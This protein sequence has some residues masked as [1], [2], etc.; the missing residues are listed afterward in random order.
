MFRVDL[1]RNGIAHSALQRF[2]N[3]IPGGIWREQGSRLT[4]RSHQCLSFWVPI[5]RGLLVLSVAIWSALAGAS[6]AAEITGFR[7]AD[8]S[9]VSVSGAIQAGDEERFVAALEAYTPQIVLLESPGGDLRSALAIGA[10]IAL[11]GVA[12][13]VPE[14]QGCFSACALIWVAGATRI[15][16][17]D[18]TIGVHGAYYLVDDIDGTSTPVISS[19]GNASIG[20]YLNE[21]GLNLQA[22]EFF[23]SAPPDGIARLT[24]LV[25]DILDI[26]VIVTSSDGV[27]RPRLPGL[28]SS[29]ELAARYAALESFC[30]DFFPVAVGR[31]REQARIW[32]QVVHDIAGAS[33]GIDHMLRHSRQARDDLERSGA[34]SW[35]LGALTSLADDSLDVGLDGPSF[36]CRRAA[37]PSEVA[38]CGAPRLWVR[39][40]ALSRI[41]GALLAQ[42]GGVAELREA[43]RAWLRVR[44]ACG[45]DIPCLDRRYRDRISAL[46]GVAIP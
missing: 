38:I 44:D 40:V 21:L 5:D 4:M 12:T 23:V 20:A 43:Q 28:Q 16:A 30:T 37:L 2:A 7:E 9:V 14:G 36:D 6:V 22:I 26:R 27:G 46:S 35:C 8:L 34:L 3:T 29:A 39:D 10:E 13:Y 24:P 1:A 19:V 41:Y 11:R 31:Y 42:R 33:P 32:L 45:A 17:A 18:A 15:M 25:A